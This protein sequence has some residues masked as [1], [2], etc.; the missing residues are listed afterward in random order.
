[1]IEIEGLTPDPDK[2]RASSRPWP[3]GSQEQERPLA[4]RLDAAYNANFTA[5]EEGIKE[6]FGDKAAKLKRGVFGH[7]IDLKD[8]LEK[9]GPYGEKARLRM[10]LQTGATDAA[11][12]DAD[13]I[14]KNIFIPLSADEKVLLDKLIR[15][16]V[17]IEIKSRNPEYRGPEGADVDGR[18]A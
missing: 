18:T 13:Q 12:Y 16:K 15:D 9:S 6:S 17:I 5:E 3:I 11:R 4:D 10:V 1:M 14:N 2:Q 7:N 8:A